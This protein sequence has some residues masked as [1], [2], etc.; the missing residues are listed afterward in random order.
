M[1]RI[2][3]ITAAI[4]PVALRSSRVP[5]RL[6]FGSI[7]M[8]SSWFACCNVQHAHGFVFPTQHL[9]AVAQVRRSYPGLF[10]A[11]REQRSGV[12]IEH[13]VGEDA[14]RDSEGRDTRPSHL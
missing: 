2:A 14:G 9:R 4:Q 11:R 12:R 7:V 5:G 6:I 3:T 1:I 8:E 10:A 13:R